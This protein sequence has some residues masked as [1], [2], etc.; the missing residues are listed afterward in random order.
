MFFLTL[1]EANVAVQALRANPERGQRLP[2]HRWP[3]PA[4]DETRTDSGPSTSRTEREALTLLATL[5][6]EA[7]FV[8]FVQESLGDYTDAQIGAVARDVHRD[9]GTVL[10]RVSALRP[11]LPNEEGAPVEIPQGFDAGRYH[12]T[13][14]VKDTPRLHDP[15]GSSWVGS[16]DV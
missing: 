7:R 12:L 13:G 9:C 3:H 16:R 5:Q 4:G 1:F 6:R 15:P 14:K 8:D 2:R 11:V 10:K